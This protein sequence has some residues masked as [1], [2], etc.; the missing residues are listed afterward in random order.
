MKSWKK[1]AAVLLCAALL[2]LSVIPAFAEKDD[3]TDPKKPNTQESV[4]KDDDQ[5]ETEEEATEDA[6][7]AADEETEEAGDKE[8]E[9]GDEETE[10]SGDEE[11]ESGDEET[12][13]AGDK[14]TESGADET[15]EADKEANGELIADGPVTLDLWEEDS[16]AR[17]MLE[18]YVAA[19][20][21]PDGEEFIPE[22]DRIAVFDLDGTLFCE[23][24]PLYLEWL[25]YMKR[26]MF[27]EDSEPGKEDTKLCRD[28]AA[29][30]IEGKLSD[31][32]EMR[33]IEA[34]TRVFAGMTYS[35]YVDYVRE[36]CS[37]PCYGYENMTVGEAFYQPMVQT[38]EY[39]TD[40]GFKCY[41]V[42]GS[43]RTFIRTVS[44]NAL[45][46]PKAQ[47]IGTDTWIVAS[48]MDEWNGGE[49]VF[50]KEDELVLSDELVMKNIKANK[51]LQM[52]ETIGQ[53]PVLSFGN[54]SGDLSMAEF[55]CWD[56]EYDAMAFMLLC[57]DTERENGNPEKAAKMEATC[58]EYGF[59]P[60]SMKNDW[61][62]IYGEDV[63][64]KEIEEIDG[65][66]SDEEKIDEMLKRLDGF[67]NAEVPVK[68]QDYA[69]LIAEAYENGEI[70]EDDVKQ[71]ILLL[72]RAL[73]AEEET[74]EAAEE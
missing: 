9:S 58:I 26:A 55:V 34:E 56:N 52:M 18:D 64:K 27:D 44:E 49:Y 32:L 48:G 72:Y 57:D 50:Q 12:E 70:S 46:I 29:G 66:L 8:T 21:D 13:E 5:A 68:P 63:V 11:T 59:V 62:T 15:E 71:A 40:N 2:S 16:E 7:K 33:Q 61:T 24:D 73:G 69:A 28:I 45:D 1:I 42:S 10:E 17:K 31:E 19:V 47:Y 30:I 60:V 23:T 36:L 67:F 54:S 20:T 37:L 22:E 51:I 4:E 3:D 53:K 41:I 14:E 35:D 39:L 65:D 74:E 38:V 25:M 43:G 6:D